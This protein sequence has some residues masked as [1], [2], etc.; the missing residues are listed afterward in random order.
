MKT[1]AC[2]WA[3]SRNTVILLP[4]LPPGVSTLP[5]SDCYFISIF[6]CCFLFFNATSGSFPGEV[7]FLAGSKCPSPE[8]FRPRLGSPPLWKPEPLEA[9]ICIGRTLKSFRTT[10]SRF[11][12]SRQ[13]PHQDGVT[14]HTTHEVQ[15][16][17]GKPKTL[18]ARDPA[19]PWDGGVQFHSEY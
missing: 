14:S 8:A 7:W 6:F 12:L 2:F 11:T 19:Y 4:V 18:D 9:K 3:T 1:P 17:H 13:R 10:S 5:D 16:A 15:R